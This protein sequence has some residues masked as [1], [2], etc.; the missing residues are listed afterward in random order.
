MLLLS[1]TLLLPCLLVMLSLS[2]IS[3]PISMVPPARLMSL[4]PPKLA[5]FF[6][7]PGLSRTLMELIFLFWTPTPTPLLVT[8]PSTRMLTTSGVL[9]LL[10]PLPVVTLNPRPLL[11]WF[12]VAPLLASARLVTLEILTFVLHALLVVTLR[13]TEPAVFAL[14]ISPTALSALSLILALSVLIPLFK[15]P[16][17]PLLLSLVLP[18]PPV[19]PPAA[20]GLRTPPTSSVVTSPA[21]PH[22]PPTSVPTMPSPL[23]LTTLET[24]SIATSLLLTSAMN[25]LPTTLLRTS[26]VLSNVLTLAK[27]VTGRTPLA[28]FAKVWG[29]G[30][31]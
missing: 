16:R 22:A 13:V 8:M 5:T 19:L 6:L 2:P 9:L 21:L 14:T 18:P 26:V 3:I 20:S 27:L 31:F 25:V 17:V 29:R 4:Q 1:P 12:L 24:S 10:L 11:S 23:P 7:T 15:W 30:S 28:E